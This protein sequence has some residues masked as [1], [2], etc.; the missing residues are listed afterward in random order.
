VITFDAPAFVANSQNYSSTAV[1]QC[2]SIAVS[3]DVGKRTASVFRW[4]KAT[5]SGTAVSSKE[6]MQN[7]SSDDSFSLHLCRHPYGALECCALAKGKNMEA[8]E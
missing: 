6:M 1:Q 5:D 2:S 8:G 3:D 4:V 7:R